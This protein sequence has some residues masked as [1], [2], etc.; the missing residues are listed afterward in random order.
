VA[1]VRQ[2][3]TPPTENQ[4]RT[5]PVT[6]EIVNASGVRD[7]AT[8]AAWR[9]GWEGFDTHI[10]SPAAS[11][12][13]YTQLID[14]TGQTK[15]SAAEGLLLALNLGPSSLQVEPSS[16]RSADYRLIV[17]QD[18]YPCTYGVTPPTG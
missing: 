18:Y 7:L 3:L 11:A 8:V 14:L 5:N 10:A 12:A 4:L 13:P 15:S 2:F 1:T 6:V 17:G 9:L 16:Q